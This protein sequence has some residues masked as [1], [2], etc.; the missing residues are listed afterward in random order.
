MTES[1]KL[2]E[3]ADVEITL[4]L[5]RYRQ[6]DTEALHQLLPFVYGEL[7]RLAHYWL[8]AQPPL[9][10]ELWQPT[11]LVNELFVSLFAGPPPQWN[12]RQH[13]FNTASLRLRAL[14]IDEARR[15][16]ADKRGGGVPLLLLDD[17]QGAVATQTRQA[18]LLALDEALQALAEHYARPAKVVE[19]RFFMGLSVTETA[20][21]LDVN[22]R[23][24]RR[25][26]EFA[27]GWLLAYLKRGR[28]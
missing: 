16:R 2:P 4:L 11:A 1:P 28:A 13:F 17:A 22:E 12:D 20:Q 19:L 23:T 24:V 25:D 21:V 26:W 10:A 27:K 15:N 5:Q 14:L 7:K 9:G 18:E 3:F 6:G 8:R